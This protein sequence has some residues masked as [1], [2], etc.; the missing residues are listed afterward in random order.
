MAGCEGL[1]QSNQ[2][3]VRLIGVDRDGAQQIAQA[4]CT[5]RGTGRARFLTIVDNATGTRYENPEPSD[6]VFVCD[7]AAR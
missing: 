4:E 5:R 2:V 3:I 6:A 1:T 7:P